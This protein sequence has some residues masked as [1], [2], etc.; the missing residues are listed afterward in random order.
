MAA[1]A[2]RLKHKMEFSDEAEADFDEFCIN[3]KTSGEAWETSKG[4]WKNISQYA[5]AFLLSST[6]VCYI[7]NSSY[8]IMVA[9]Q[10][11]NV[12]DLPAEDDM[13]GNAV[14][15]SWI[16]ACL[17]TK[18]SQ[19][20][21]AVKMSISKDGVA[22]RNIAC[23]TK[24]LISKS[25]KKIPQTQ[26]LYMW[27]SIVDKE[28][29]GDPAKSGIRSVKLVDFCLPKWVKKINELTPKVQISQGNGECPGK[30]Q[31][32]SRHLNEESDDEDDENTNPSI[33][34]P[35]E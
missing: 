3:I 9:L 32:I 17:T 34:T 8:Y 35:P 33:I 13:T 12:K 16:S 18:C 28:V 29:Y 2:R 4:L 22:L 7:G 14:L 20:K 24:H 11:T 31:R 19:I 10:D 30:R 6:A 23:L 21:D 1:T 27:L 26:Q 5:K 15:Q 25:N